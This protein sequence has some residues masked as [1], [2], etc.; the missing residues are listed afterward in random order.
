MK[1][2]HLDS[3]MLN[4]Y[5]DD[6]C[7]AAESEQI[8]AHLRDCDQCSDYLETMNGAVQKLKDIAGATEAPH[9]IWQDVE[10]RLGGRAVIRWP[11]WAV[12]ALAAASVLLFALLSVPDKT[13]PK[14]IDSY[15]I[16][17]V[18]YLEGTQ[19]VDNWYTDYDE[20]DVMDMFISGDL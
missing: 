1:N 18:N 19:L 20:S 12:S 5:V 15:I 11:V 2:T 17:Q 10:T 16:T 13:V 9:T 3:N 4:R 14:G 6:E 8:R 7:A